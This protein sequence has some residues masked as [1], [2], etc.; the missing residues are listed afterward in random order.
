[1]IQIPNN[2]APLLISGIKDAIAYHE[3]LLR[4]ETL[5]QREDYEEHL[6]QLSQFFEYLK[7]EY[8]KVEEQAGIA[9]DR[10]V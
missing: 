7:A 2:W 9:L 3:Q 10:L 4:S 5:R 8:K 6:V 1:M